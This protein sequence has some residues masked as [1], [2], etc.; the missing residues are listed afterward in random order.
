MSSQLNIIGLAA[1]PEAKLLLKQICDCELGAL[2]E[3]HPRALS[4]FTASRRQQRQSL[5]EEARRFAERQIQ[6]LRLR[7]RDNPRL[8]DNS[9]VIDEFLDEAGEVLALGE[10]PESSHPCLVL[11]DSAVIATPGLAAVL[12][13]NLLLEADAR[14]IRGACLR[15]PAATPPAP[16]LLEELRRY[17]P[18]LRLEPQS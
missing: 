16:E 3:G 11:D 6:R 7:C 8:I 15:H 12:G 2:L 17:L 14:S 13:V 5:R 18:K 10:T 1:S 4:F 9:D